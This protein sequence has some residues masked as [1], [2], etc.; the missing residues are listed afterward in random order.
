M[1]WL[2]VERNAF[3]ETPRDEELQGLKV[4]DLFN[5]GSKEWDSE[6]IEELFNERDERAM[7]DI[8]LHGQATLDTRIW[9]FS[10]NGT[11]TV[12]SGYR[13]IV[14]CLA[15]RDHLK[16]RRPWRKV[17]DL[18]APPRLRTFAWR[19]GRGVVPT[20]LAIQKRHIPAPSECEICAREMENEWHLFLQCSFAQD[21]WRRARL[22]P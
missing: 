2:R 22:L 19:L 17:W 4:C 21:C 12:Q 16:V 7:F 1:P 11:Y 18:E 8:P 9:P 20:R 5:P 10:R 13:F 15:P 6:L 14:E 3:V